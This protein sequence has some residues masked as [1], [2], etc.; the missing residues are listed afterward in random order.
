MELFSNANLQGSGIHGHSSYSNCCEGVVDYKAFLSLIGFLAL[1]TWF[2]QNLIEMSMLEMMRR[3]KRNIDN[4][5]TLHNF[6]RIVNEG[7][8]T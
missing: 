1:A 8:K 7:K 3:K 2:L 4:I 5:L 6:V